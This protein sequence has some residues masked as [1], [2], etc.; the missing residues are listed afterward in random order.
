MT[1]ACTPSG[2][3]SPYCTL[4]CASTH[5]YTTAEATDENASNAAHNRTR[6]MFDP[7]LTP[8]IYNAREPDSPVR[9]RSDWPLSL[10]HI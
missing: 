4:P 2:G 9:M 7:R 10:I 5:L 6:F 1:S 3:R 8:A